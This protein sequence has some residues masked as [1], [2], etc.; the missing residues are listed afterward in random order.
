M[1]HFERKNYAGGIVWRENGE[2]IYEGPD[3]FDIAIRLGKA[4][5][6]G[7]IELMESYQKGSYRARRNNDGD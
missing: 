3:I 1:R 4:T 6:R 5:A 7:Q 2:I